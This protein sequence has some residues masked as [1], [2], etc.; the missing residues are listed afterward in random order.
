MI[1][2]FRSFSTELKFYL[3]MNALFSF[4]TGLSG[5]FQN[6]FLWKLDK[7]YSLLAYYSLYW[8]VAIIISFG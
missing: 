5:V 2:I 1:S 6:V 8:S 3:I 7:T 4:G